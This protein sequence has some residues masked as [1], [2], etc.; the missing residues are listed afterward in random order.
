[1]KMKKII[2]VAFLSLAS[3][4]LFAWGQN[5]HRIVAQICYDNLNDKAKKE[6]N[7]L[8]GENYLS[9][10]ATWPDFIRSEKTW[11]F[12]KNW[13]FVTINPNKTIN[14]I[15]EDGKKNPK[16]ENV[17]EAIELM[18]SIL[19]N[20]AAATKF[21][22]DT[23]SHYKANM[24]GGNIKLTALAFLVHFVGDIHQP[25]HVGKNNDFGGNKISV[26]F[27][28][29]KTNLHEVWDER[30][31]E[32]EQLS[33]NQLSMYVEK[34]TSTK[35]AELQKAT[36]DIWATESV[37][38]REKIYNTLYDL[39]DKETGLPN[40]SYQYQHDYFPLL[41][42]RLGAAGYRAAEILNGLFN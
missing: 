11:D 4:E 24:L 27:F 30:I 36:I 34:H 3:H 39:T 15:I 26:L 9:Q 18:K 10:I 12:T 38:L 41:E 29:E 20:D 21:F 23:I 37:A 7:S 33:F 2:F 40:L 22:Q 28:D 25:M 31:I 32:Q 8:L 19:K 13:H 16:I 14:Q 35:K 42:D 5:G 1:M 17:V 6:V